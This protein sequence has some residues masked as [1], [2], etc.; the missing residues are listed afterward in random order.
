MIMKHGSDS[1][2]AEGSPPADQRG[3]DEQDLVGA[4]LDFVRGFQETSGGASGSPT[5][6]RQKEDLR[7]WAGRLGLLLNRLMV[8]L[9]GFR[10]NNRRRI[11][12]GG[13]QSQDLRRAR[14]ESRLCRRFARPFR[15]DP[16]PPRRWVPG[17]HPGDAGG[18][19]RSAGSEDDKREMTFLRCSSPGSR[20][21]RSFP[22][23]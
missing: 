8:R 6:A 17:I 11:L 10:E 7:E 13:R 12:P 23:L 20:H 2:K 18:G 1:P 5:L 22:F 9:A 14:Q 19:A 3:G 15:R 16:L 4:A 21:R